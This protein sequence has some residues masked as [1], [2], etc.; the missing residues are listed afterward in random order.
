MARRRGEAGRDSRVETSAQGRPGIVLS[1][2][3]GALAV[4]D[5]RS[6]AGSL[7]GPARSHGKKPGCGPAGL[8]K[9][10]PASDAGGAARK[11]C[12]EENEIA[13]EC[14]V[15]HFAAHR[16]GVSGNLAH[17]R[18]RRDAGNSAALMPRAPTVAVPPGEPGSARQAARRKVN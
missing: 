2:G 1:L 4:F 12:A 16:P 6:D 14:A 10:A 15:D 9:A 5:R 18:D 3:P 13:E 11:S 7:P 8:R 17:G